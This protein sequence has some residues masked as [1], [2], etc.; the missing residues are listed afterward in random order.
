LRNYRR[1][2]GLC[3]TYGERWSRDHR[4]SGTVQLHVLQEVIDLFQPDLSDE[5]QESSATSSAEFHLIQP[6]TVLKDPGTLTFQLSGVIQGQTVTLLVDSGST[7]SFIN[8]KFVAQLSDVTPLK[9]VL[10]VKVA[11]GAQMQSTQGI[12]NCPWSCD[13]YEFHANFKFLKL[14]T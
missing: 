11:D 13:G 14:G 4:C 3:Y 1:A 6:V 9:N 5:E 10:R 8:D 2:R 7:H 12:M